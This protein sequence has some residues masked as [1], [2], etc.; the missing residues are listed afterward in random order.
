MACLNTTAQRI[1]LEIIFRNYLAKRL[2]AWGYRNMSGTASS[3]AHVEKALVSSCIPT[4]HFILSNQRSQSS[5]I[6]DHWR[7]T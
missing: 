3:A 1:D 6:A 4:F 2:D 5:K 7:S